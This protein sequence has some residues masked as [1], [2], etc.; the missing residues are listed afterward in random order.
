MAKSE[1][2]HDWVSF[3]DPEG[4]QMWIFDATYF[5]S[6]WKCIYG[7]GCKGIHETDTT[8]EMQGC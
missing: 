1:E 8:D 5:L 3:E 2:V 4:G 7:E 6:N